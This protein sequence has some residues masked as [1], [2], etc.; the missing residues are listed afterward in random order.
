LQKL[1]K[2]LSFFLIFLS[3]IYL[4][5]CTCSSDTKKNDEPQPQSSASNLPEGSFLKIPNE[6]NSFL[7]MIENPSRKETLLVKKR[8]YVY[9]KI[10]DKVILE[11]F[12]PHGKA[13]WKNNA[14][15][16]I[17]K[18]PGMISKDESKNIL[19]Y[20]FNVSTHE[21]TVLK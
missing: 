16:Q 17:E 13:F 9:D 8:I 6:S 11:D 7:L 20:I 4:F 21:K 2:R 10:N 1:Y 3:L 5:S 19:G 14:E 12:I 18:Y 15:L